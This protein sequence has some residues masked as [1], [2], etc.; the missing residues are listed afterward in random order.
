MRL[1]DGRGLACLHNPAIGREK[2]LGIGSL[3]GASKKKKVVVVGGGPAGMAA[4]RVAAQRGHDVT[5]I[6]KDHELGGQNRMTVKIASRA[7]YS[8]VTRWQ[9]L[10]L[11]RSG[12]KVRLGTTATAASILGE[13]PDAVVIAAG[14]LPRKTGYSSL[15]PTVERLPGVD[16]TNVFTVWD[17]FDA[18]KKL[19]KT[20]A[21]IDEDPHMSGIYT[22]EYLADRGHTVHVVTPQVHPGDYLEISFVPDLYR[23]ILPKGVQIHANTFITRIEGARL[24]LEDRYTGQP[25]S[26]EGIDA[27]VL[28]MGNRANDGL[29]RELKGKVAVHAVGDALAPRRLDEAIIDGER[30]GRMI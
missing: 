26:L 23:R 6:E 24:M 18:G 4:A 9:R 11:E 25:R 15:R 13:K 7:S 21:L 30:I 12:A 5:L 19:G 22:A 1:I 29:Y 20:V 16:Q 14:S 17:V 27:I 2:E 28:A 8:E 10:E 3:K